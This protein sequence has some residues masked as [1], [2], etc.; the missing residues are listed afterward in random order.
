MNEFV[1]AGVLKNSK[2]NQEGIDFWKNFWIFTFRRVKE[3]WEMMCPVYWTRGRIYGIACFIAWCCL[4]LSPMENFSASFFVCFN[5]YTC[6]HTR[7]IYYMNQL[8]FSTT[9]FSLFSVIFF[10]HIGNTVIYSY[11]DSC[12]NNHN[13][14]IIKTREDFFKKIYL[15]LYL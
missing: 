6:I 3:S 1:Y 14:T 9:W 4:I 2:F 15:S 5:V 10:N 8:S 12:R 7:K 13:N 11:A